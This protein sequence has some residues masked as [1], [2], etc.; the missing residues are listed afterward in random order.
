MGKKATKKTLC[1]VF[2]VC[3][4][5]DRLPIVIYIGHAFMLL[6]KFMKWVASHLNISSIRVSLK[7]SVVHAIVSILNDIKR[8]ITCLSHPQSPVYTSL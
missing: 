4:A 7:G 3:A 6:G 5:G 2:I 8:K 1:I